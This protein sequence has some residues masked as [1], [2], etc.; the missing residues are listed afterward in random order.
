[1]TIKNC[2][3]STYQGD[4]ELAKFYQKFNKKKNNFDRALDV[5]LIP[6]GG[7]N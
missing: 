5:T 6:A 3:V 7:L 1:M 2:F 4:W